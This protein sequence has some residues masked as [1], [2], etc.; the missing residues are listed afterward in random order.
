[1]TDDHELEAELRALG[2]TLTVDPV[3]DDL[4][5]RVLA[6][7]PV[8]RP[9]PARRFLRRLVL[10][11]KARR[12]LVAVI[13]AALIAGLL[14]A[15]PVRAAVIEWLRVG[16]IVFQSAPAPGG[17]VRPVSP[18]GPV[19]IEVAT[20]DQARTM[21]DFPIGLPTDLGPPTRVAVS[22]DR[23]LVELEFAT[24]AGPVLLS[25]FDGSLIMF[26]KRNWD[27]LI[28]VEVDGNLAVWL[29]DP[30]T[31]SYVDPDGVEH[32]DEARLSGPTLAYEAYP[33]GPGRPV[34]VRLE[35]SFNQDRAIALAESLTFP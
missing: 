3:P 35:G 28:R 2:R 17:T 11:A 15:S 4:A 13:I 9:H 6:R 5:M 1:M 12:R 18:G 7:L 32:T 22:A 10:D 27:R 31:I 29:P 8:R 24:A 33:A 23:R 25:Q 20:V 21:I 34:T 14:L 30:H 19:M 16:G 26:V